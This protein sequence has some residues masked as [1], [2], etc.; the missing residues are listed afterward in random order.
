MIHALFHWIR[1]NFQSQAFY[2]SDSQKMYSGIGI[3]QEI[4][5]Q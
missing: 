1:L 2:D 3:S 4:F 5:L